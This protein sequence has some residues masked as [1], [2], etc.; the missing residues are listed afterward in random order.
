MHITD[1]K[2]SIKY[3]FKNKMPARKGKT[4]GNYLFSTITFHCSIEVPSRTRVHARLPNSDVDF[5]LSQVSHKEK[6]SERKQFE[7][8]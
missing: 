5:L 7:I 4:T 3:N 2:S 6:N 8:E 1:D